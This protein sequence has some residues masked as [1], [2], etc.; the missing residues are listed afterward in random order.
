MSPMAKYADG[1]ASDKSWRR[2]V[3]EY[4]LGLP[5]VLAI[6][7]IGGYESAIVEE[8]IITSTRFH[9]AT[10]RRLAIAPRLIINYTAMIF[11][12]YTV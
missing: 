3:D 2:N 8:V 9:N 11:D 6:R 5:A 7:A 10:A 4:S 12:S 1:Y